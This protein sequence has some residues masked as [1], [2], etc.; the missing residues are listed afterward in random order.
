MRYPSV[1][2]VPLLPDSTS[3]YMTAGKPIQGRQNLSWPGA[4]REK[5]LTPR[6][7][8]C[9]FPTARHPKRQAESEAPMVT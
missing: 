2:C 4:R 7:V 1:R 8:F 3:L 9:S 6:K 5:M